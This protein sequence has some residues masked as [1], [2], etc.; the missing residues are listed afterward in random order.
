MEILEKLLT[1]SLTQ[2]AFI[3]LTKPAVIEGIDYNDV[4]N[5]TL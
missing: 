2:I 3:R 5:V 1:G 4:M